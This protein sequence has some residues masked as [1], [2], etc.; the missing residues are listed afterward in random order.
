MVKKEFTYKGKT[1]P[2]LQ[3]MTINDFMKIATARVRRT[4]K[5]GLNEQQKRLLEKIRKFKSGKLKKP[6]KTQLRDMIVI[7]EMIGITIH[8][9]RGKEFMPILITEEMLG[10]YLGEFTYNRQRV[11]HSAPGIGATKSSAAVSV[12]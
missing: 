3:S 11:E 7:P 9:H 4:L 1:L 5:K 2:E 6:I 10:H 12:K 8:I